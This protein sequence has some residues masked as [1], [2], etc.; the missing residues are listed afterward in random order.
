M[1]LARRHPRAAGAV[2]RGRAD[3]QGVTSPGPV[4][5]RTVAAIGAWWRRAVA[6][7]PPAG[8]VHR[9]RVPRDTGPMSRFHA[10]PSVSRHRP[11]LTHL[12]CGSPPCHGLV[13]SD[14]YW[15]CMSANQLPMLHDV[16]GSQR[17]CTATGSSPEPRLISTLTISSPC[18]HRKTLGRID[19]RIVCLGPGLASMAKEK[20]VAKTV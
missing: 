10:P 16:R 11:R 5:P 6:R 1:A 3:V 9:I 2:D 17:N 18:A 19:L 12:K 14:H 13:W 20:S 15:G 4:A 8:H 7:R